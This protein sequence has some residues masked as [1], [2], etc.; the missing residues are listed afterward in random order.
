MNKPV[1]PTGENPETTREDLQRE[2]NT[3]R[4]KCRDL[5]TKHEISRLLTA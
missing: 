2:L 5:E 1:E 4:N 3:L